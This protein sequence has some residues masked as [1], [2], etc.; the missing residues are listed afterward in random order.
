[1]SDDP[2]EAAKEMKN[3]FICDDVLFGV[4][5]FCGHFVLGLK[6][7]LLSDRFDFLVDAHF[8]TKE[9]SLGF[10]DIRRADDGDGVEI[11]TLTPQSPKKP[12]A[13]TGKSSDCPDKAKLDDAFGAEEPFANGGFDQFDNGASPWT[14]E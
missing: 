6:V 4:F 5:K 10:L 2:K 7:A 3:I 9:W 8:R 11:V 13:L 12:H 1:M 14:V